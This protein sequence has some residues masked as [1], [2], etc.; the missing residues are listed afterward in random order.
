MPYSLTSEEDDKLL[1][2]RIHKQ[3]GQ[4]EWTQQVGTTRP[5]VAREDAG[6]PRETTVP[7]A[8][9]PRES[10]TVTDGEVVV[11]HF[12]NGDLAAYNFA[13][14]QLW[15]RNLQKD[16]GVYTIWWG[17]ANSLSSSATW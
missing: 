3:K 8:P 2:L 11:A 13:G 15:L 6:Q 10:F 12:G 16:F 5:I 4:V 14:K 17:H 9:K 7:Q 1:L